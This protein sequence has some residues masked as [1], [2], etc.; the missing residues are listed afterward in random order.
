[1][2]IREEIFIAAPPETVWAVFSDIDNWKHW[3]P[4]CR[5]CRLVRGEGLQ[6][7]ACISFQLKPVFFPIRIEPEVSRCQ[8]S[9]TVVWTG[10]KWGLH[11]EHTFLFETVK[12]GTRL[13][14][15]ETFSGPVLW[16]LRLAGIPRRL[17]RLTRQLLAAIKSAAENHT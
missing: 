5:E 8:P 10:S 14:S 7:G 9:Q 4:V 3:N 6:P 12:D 15:I 2:V 1:M 17:H 11:A 13:E 16:P